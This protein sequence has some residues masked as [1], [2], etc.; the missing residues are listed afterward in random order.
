MHKT[1][2]VAFIFLAV[3]LFF[4]SIAILVRLASQAGVLMAA[5]EWWSI[6]WQVLVAGTLVALSFVALRAGR[7]RW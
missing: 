6:G 5:S 4:W 3:I 2:A 7:Q 1:L